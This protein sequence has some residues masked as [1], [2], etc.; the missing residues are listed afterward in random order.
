AGAEYGPA[1]RW[2]MERFA[3]VAT[4]L[5]EHWPQ[6][7]WALFGAPSEKAMGEKLSSLMPAARHR[8]LVGATT[9]TGLIEELRSCRLLVTNDTGTM[10][11]AAA[12]GVPT[13][14]IFGSTEPVLTGP[15][16]N[17][18]RVVRHHVPCSPCFKRECPFGHYDCLT[19]VTVERVVA[20]VAQELQRKVEILV[21]A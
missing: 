14:S 17:H 10:H 19:G 3:E 20:E 8:N 5:S 1:K 15:V 21:P 13:V 7:E 9:L 12:L 2:P 16:G 11:L 18:H 4:K 6:I